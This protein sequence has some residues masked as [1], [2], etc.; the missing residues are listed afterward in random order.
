[1]VAL[2]L[3]RTTTYTA[4]FG[5]LF[6]TAVL[7]D[8]LCHFNFLLAKVEKEQHQKLDFEVFVNKLTLAIIVFSVLD[9][10]LH[11]HEMAEGESGDW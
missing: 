11:P 9:P 6:D 2:L 1:M 10:S 3:N 4:P 7:V 8:D 5:L